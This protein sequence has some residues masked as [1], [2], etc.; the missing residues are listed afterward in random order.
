MNQKFV[1]KHSVVAVALTLTSSQFALAQESAQPIAK[2][3]ITGS[4][5]KRAAKEGTS[6]V[7]VLSAKQIAATGAS[8]VQDLLHSIPA[9]GSGSSVDVIDGGFSKGASTASLR[10]LGSSSTLI[11]LNGRR[12]TASAYADPNQGK[13]AVYD[14]NT[15]PVSAIERVEIFKDGASAVYG[16]DAI[17]G[18]VNFITKSDYQGAQLSANYSGTAKNEFN[19]KAVN[20]IFGFGDLEKDRYNVFVSADLAER[21]S[22]L[23]R[24]VDA[25]DKTRLAAINNRLNP[26]SSSLSDQ[27]F[28]Y[29]ERTAGSRSF[30]NSYALRADVI[31]RTNCP[32]N[33]QITGSVAD[34]NLL[35]TSTLV[36]RTFCNFNLND[37]AEAQGAGKDYNVL[38]RATVQLSP[39]LQSF[40]EL[41]YSRSERTYLG[42]PSAVQSTSPSTVF[43]AGAAQDFQIILPIGHPDN[44]FPTSRSAVGFRL[45]GNGGS[46]NLNQ[47]VRL[48]TGLKGST[49]GFDW[50]T[51]ALYN[52]SER[53]ANYYGLLYRP[54]LA[55][56][57]TENRTIAATLADP[58]S[59][60]T[61]SNDGYSQ[62][63]QLDAKASTTIGKLPGG[64]IGL[65]FGVEGRQ[66]KIGL[67]A[68]PL[69]QR[70]DIVG[71]ANTIINGSRKV[72]SAFVETRT[73]FA[74]TFEM[75]F[76]ARYDKYPD[77]KSFVPKVGA[78]WDVSPMASVRGSF[79]R[80]FRAPALIQISP[81]GVQ[82]FS[83]VTDSVRCPD[84]V[85]PVNGADQ[86]DCAKGISSLS[87]G[88]P[89]LAPEKSKSFSLGV[90]L[91]PTRDIDVLVDY[92]H[93]R[94]EQETA[95]LSAQYVIDHP[96]QFPGAI[97]RANNAGSLL[98][99]ANGNTIPNSGPLTAVNRS[100][101]NQ[102]S[103][104][105]SGLAFE[106]AMRKSLGEHGMLT[107]K[108]NWEYAISYRRAERPGE[109]EA[110]AVGT[111]GGISDWAT[112]VGDIPRN[113][114]S[115]TLNWTR[116]VHSL[117]GSIDYVGPVSLLRRSDN[118][119]IY[120]V[121]YCQYGVGQ[122]STAYQLGGLA[123]FSDYSNGTCGVN[124]FT[125]L[126]MAYTYTG[127]KN[128]TLNLN[129][130]N[131]LDTAAPY[132]P[133]YP[134]GGYN[135]QLH[136]ANGRYFKAS[137]TYTF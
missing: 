12:I 107:G 99:D 76:A 48:V 72:Y 58:T 85:K 104:E 120:P 92:Y 115:Y 68:D 129:I 96:N 18:V 71:L 128:V 73:P 36:G 134:T 94:K 86:A 83:T 118:N 132:D 63:V 119:V 126:G 105:V 60:A 111:A 9:F 109:V 49:G 116:N 97:L 29:R 6:P 127:I 15:I 137:A 14:L 21:G 106:V 103:T 24:D 64:D 33:K 50:E 95:L 100:Y 112:S 11:L 77:N 102:G 62:V 54:T 87:A 84:G 93:I 3:T 130:R 57:M 133:R 38:S 131:L 135:S 122:P 53:T 78:K 17:A 5:I 80:G 37:V 25:I 81:G 61:V 55:R 69:T 13:S 41:G 101:V 110:N 27:P 123:K 70:G 98:V 90:I 19:R 30:A 88:T 43:S 7:E 8:T 82:S 31:N 1:L 75:D 42:A 23:I 65:A 51:A 35:A 40:T 66:E 47:A 113:R 114:G 32:A 108:L 136:N 117:S 26:Y 79:A 125:T 89:G 121:P 10:G 52:R 59:A 22:T 74:K 28:F 39:D 91:A 67:S 46:D 44:P 4:N 45:N 56:I 34:N 16:S 2:V 124:S 20:G